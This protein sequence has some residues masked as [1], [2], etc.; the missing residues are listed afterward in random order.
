MRFEPDEHSIRC[1]QIPGECTKN[2]Q[3][4]I[5]GVDID[6]SDYQFASQ[7]YLKPHHLQQH[8]EEALN[9][10]TLDTAVIDFA[11]G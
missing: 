3:P 1:Y 9:L 8:A 7:L 2:G 5:G 4:I 11:N 6:A 10:L